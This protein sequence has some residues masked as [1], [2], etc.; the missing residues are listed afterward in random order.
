MDSTRKKNKYESQRRRKRIRYFRKLNQYKAYQNIKKHKRTLIRKDGKKSLNVNCL[1]NTSATQYNGEYQDDFVNGC[2]EYYYV[3]APYQMKIKPLLNSKPEHQHKLPTRNYYELCE[4]WRSISSHKETT[5]CNFKL[6]YKHNDS[7]P[8]I[9]GWNKY[10]KAQF[11]TFP[12]LKQMKATAHTFSGFIT[13]DLKYIQFDD[14]GMNH[15]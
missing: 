13:N 4:Q 1:N 14:I 9:A 6:M 10:G 11:V 12:Q 3:S 8:V 5:I 2:S 15:N 7:H